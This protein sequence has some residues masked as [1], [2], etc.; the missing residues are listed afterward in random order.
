MVK[1]TKSDMNQ[2]STATAALGDLILTN[3]AND[4][5]TRKAKSDLV[6]LQPQAD[7][8]SVD[9]PMAVTTNGVTEVALLLDDD[10]TN[11]TLF[12]SQWHLNNTVTGID[13]NVLNVWPDYTGEGV[14]IGIWDD[15]VEYT[16]PDLMDNYVSSLHIPESNA[17]PTHDPYPENIFSRHGTAVAGLIAAANNDLGVVGVAYEAS[18][19]G[20][21]MFEDP[22]LDFIYSFQHL[23]DFDV[24]NHSWGWTGAFAV[25]VLSTDPETKLFF[26]GWQQSVIDGR[27]GLGTINV[28]SAG[29]DRQLMRHTNDSS[30]TSMPETIAVAAVGYDGFV[31]F[32]STP[33]SSL[34]ISAPSSDRTASGDARIVTTDRVDENGYNF[35]DQGT[36]NASQGDL[37]PSV[38]D[39]DYTTFGGTSA[40]APIVSGVVALVL[41]AN[42]NLGWRDVQEILSLSARHVGSDI[43]AGPAFDELD[44]WQ[45]N[46]DFRWNGGGRHFSND[47]GNG[48]IDA[49][50]AVRLAETWAEV[51]SVSS[52][53]AQEHVGTWTGETEIDRTGLEATTLT[54]VV[55]SGVELEMVELQIGGF[56]TQIL[57]GIDD[58]YRDVMAY[59]QELEITLT[60]PGGT[61]STL[62]APILGFNY[63]YGVDL[64][65]S[66]TSNAFRGE[67]ATGEW[68]LSLSDG[69]NNNLFNTLLSADLFML[70][71]AASNDDTFVFTDE[72]S[73]FAGGEWGHSSEITDTDGGKDA[74]N[75]AAVT[76]NTHLNFAAG[77][78][79]VDGVAVSDL[80]GIENAFTG[81]GNDELFGGNGSNWLTGGR[82][83]DI[84]RGGNGPDR[85][86]GGQ[87]DD[88]IE[89]GNGPDRISDGSGVDVMSGGQGAD[90]FVLTFDGDLDTILDFRSKVDMLVFEGVGFGDLTF[91]DGGDFVR[92]DVDNGL[93]T[94]ILFVYG[95]GKKGLEVAD[96][97]IDALQFV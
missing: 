41:E 35:T 20:V 43:G 6:F 14:T 64:L 18:I 26:D 60:S 59:W 45:F 65:W 36:G 8:A 4:V 33:G 89:G 13:I 69:W 75:A 21:D 82:G 37:N 84:I 96:L 38:T 54:F 31:S 66:Y 27:G 67:D 93:L 10:P 87:G 15:G 97:G 68:T 80:S 39:L 51:P 94:D 76:S 47:Y 49:H 7:L 16:H 22:T 86:E 71:D 3:S 44:T 58:V 79:Q 91:S 92:V 23:S 25:G 81:D 53:W 12:D 63:Y 24:T 29:N 78:G 32:Y 74:I 57:N 90:T 9:G 77:T 2:R 62:A 34:L 55:E 5:D 56:L 42:P 61:I 50:A 95:E 30:M 85:L 11:D 83:N 40:A 17:G 72:F 46:A 28:T 73:D 70:G 48:L 1:N 52:N 88:L 19:S